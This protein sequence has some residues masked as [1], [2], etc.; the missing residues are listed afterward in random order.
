[1]TTTAPYLEF[2]P[3]L[4][5]RELAAYYLSASLREVDYLRANGQIVAVGAGKRVKFRKEDLDRY[6]NR[7][8]GRDR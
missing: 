4:M 3:A 8:G 1:M 2:P 7:L 5:T 6:V